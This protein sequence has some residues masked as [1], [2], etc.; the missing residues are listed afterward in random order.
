MAD[1]NTIDFEK[2]RRKRRRKGKQSQREAD[3][4]RRGQETPNLPAPYPEIAVSKE[5]LPSR[6]RDVL[7]GEIRPTEVMGSVMAAGSG[8]AILA[9]RYLAQRL[10]SPDGPMVL[11]ARDK[12]ALELAPK[13]KFD[14]TR[15]APPGGGGSG[16]PATDGRD[17]IT[18][19]AGT[20]TVTTE[21]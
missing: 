19:L 12:I 7:F 8:L 11:T 16:P 21:T 18:E 20:D 3:K 5:S 4:R 9:S 1:D 15:K 10:S 6:E 14:L 17:P 2:A 13:M